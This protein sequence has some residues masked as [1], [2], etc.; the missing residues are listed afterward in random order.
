MPTLPSTRGWKGSFALVIELNSFNC[1]CDG[2]GG[3]GG[4]AMGGTVVAW[5]K[6]EAQSQV[7]S[8]R[9]ST[10]LEGRRKDFAAGPLSFWLC[11]VPVEQSGLWP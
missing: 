7:Y 9:R 10:G 5:R 11:L 4:S 1:G 6:V 8:R 3:G 2:G